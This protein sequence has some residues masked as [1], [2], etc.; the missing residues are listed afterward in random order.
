MDRAG[1]SGLFREVREESGAKKVWE[2]EC[3]GVGR[4]LDSGDLCRCGLGGESR[5]CCSR[6]GLSE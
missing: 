5:S 6:P 3:G 4:A 2:A 1:S